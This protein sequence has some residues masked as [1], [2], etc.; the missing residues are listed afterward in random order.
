MNGILRSVVDALLAG[1]MPSARRQLASF[2]RQYAETIV[3]PDGR[4]TS[5][6]IDDAIGYPLPKELRSGLKQAIEGDGV[7]SCEVAHVGPQIALFGFAATRA[8][9]QPLGAARRSNSFRSSASVNF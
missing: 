3:S 7:L 6:G 4:L 9:L 8:D 5:A 2:P 1:D